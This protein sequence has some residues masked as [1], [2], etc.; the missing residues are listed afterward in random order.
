[1]VDKAVL[2]PMCHIL[3]VLINTRHRGQGN[4]SVIIFSIHI[5]SEHFIAICETGI[6]EFEGSN[7]RQKLIRG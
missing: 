2:G 4:I 3:I 6:W 7:S 1:M 5:T